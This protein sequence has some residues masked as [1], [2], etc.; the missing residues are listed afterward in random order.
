MRVTVVK[1]DYDKIGYYKDL[2]KDYVDLKYSMEV[3]DEYINRC[4]RGLDTIW[5]DIKAERDV[6]IDTKLLKKDAIIV[7][8]QLAVLSVICNDLDTLKEKSDRGFYDSL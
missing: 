3:I 5:E 6:T 7:S 8:N 2:C 4:H 1:S